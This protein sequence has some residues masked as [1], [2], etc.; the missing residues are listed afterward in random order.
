MSD[1]ILTEDNRLAPDGHEVIAVLQRGHVAVGRYR[2]HG[3]IGALEQ[4]AIVRYW[5]TKEGLGELAMKGPL[6][7]TKLDKC[8]DLAFHIREAIFIMEVKP[9]A[10]RDYF[11]K[12]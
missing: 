1:Q 6:A 9:D 3:N 5:G 7:N 4:A 11:D 2:Q 8:P 12:H 10:W